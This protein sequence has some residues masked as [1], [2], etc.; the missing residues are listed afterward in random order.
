MSVSVVL[1]PNPSLLTGPGT[2]TWLVG[3]NGEL[4]CID[5]G[6]EDPEHLRHIED[7]V[8]ERH[9]RITSVLLTHSHPDHRPLAKLLAQRTGA[10]LL[11]WDPGDDGAQ[12]L[13]DGDTVQ[14]GGV[15]LRAVHTPGH[16]SDHLCFFD[17][18]SSEL[19]AGDHILSGMTTVINPPDGDMTA[20]MD[21]LQRVL[22]L[23]PRIIHPG[24]GTS[25]DDGIATIERYISHRLE[26]EAQVADAVRRRGE[27]TAPIDIVPDIYAAY[28]EALHAFA[29]RS[30][31]AHLDK[32]VREGRATLSEPGPPPRYAVP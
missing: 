9:A 1:A 4:T 25:I 30:V 16:A 12:P 8:R 2:N 26:R 17:A 28:P 23:R 29:A 18:A 13:R 5:P 21:S 15:E 19:F 14:A 10:T 7:A 31:Q 11:G 32:L 24:H 27:P 6:P 3:G 22:A 20:Y